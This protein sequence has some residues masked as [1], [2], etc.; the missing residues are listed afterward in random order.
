MSNWPPALT[1]RVVAEAFGLAD[2]YDG[3]PLWERWYE[4]AL[5]EGVEDELA[6]LGR[7]LIREAWSQ[8]WDSRRAALCGWA[9]DGEQLLELALEQP[10]LAARR[11]QG[12]LDC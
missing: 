11:W 6:S 2:G 3:D 1:E 12:L 7:T 5:D 9:D 8:R 10:Y 4:R